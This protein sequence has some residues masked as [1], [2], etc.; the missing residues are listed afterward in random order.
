MNR[1]LL[2]L[3]IFFVLF[4]CKKEDFSNS[5][6]ASLDFSSDTIIFDTTF[7]SVGTPTQKLM[8]YNRNSFSINT[9]ITLIGSNQGSFRMTVDGSSATTNNI[10][11]LEI[12]AR[13]S[14][15]I[16]LEVTPDNSPNEYILT[17]QVIFN[18]GNNQQSVDL[19]APYRDAYFHILKDN[20][21]TNTNGEI[22]NYRYYSI[23]SHTTWS[24][25]KAHVVYGSIV[26]EP[27]ASLTIEEGTKVYFHNNSGIYVGNPILVNSSNV[28]ENNGS[29]II[30]GS[31]GNE[32][33][34]QG[35]RLDEWY[36]DLPG[37]WGSITFVPGSQNNSINYAIIKNGT[38]GIRADSTVGNNPVVELNNTIIRNMS[39][40]GILGQ[41]SWITANNC[42][43]SNCGQYTLAC[44]IGGEYSFKH[45]TFANYWYYNARNTPS[46][47]L[48]NYYEDTQGN[49]RIR[50][51]KD[52]YFGNCIIAGNLSTEVSFQKN[53]GANFNYN[54]D[55]CLIK[56]DPAEETNTPNY[57]NCIINQNPAFTE[58]LEGDFSL[59]EISPA[60]DA[61]D[62]NI[63]I[64]ES[65]LM[66]GLSGNTRDNNP[67]IGALE[68]P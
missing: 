4:S 32:V 51:L 7:H 41:G 30:N 33:T 64:S 49:T 17:T 61:A 15:F 1:I 60:I 59:T 47:L 46:I 8:V 22:I 5:P 10:I 45:C 34:F 57:N 19:V 13:D 18:T 29:L 42:L 35:D 37:Q 6:D 31:L 65:I 20:L 26:I 48:N 11:S 58:H 56:L 63:T 43:V 39:S 36:K 38:V 3:I 62:P 21:F 40:I 67:D 52:A 23:D 16:F 44:N 28:P 54:F 66:T 14:A 50:E 55:H 25:D 68:N 27:D 53:E 24:A 9:D 2:K 12:N